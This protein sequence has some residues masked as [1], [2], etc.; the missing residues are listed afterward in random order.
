[1]KLQNMKKWLGSGDDKISTAVQ[2][3][4]T[5]SETDVCKVTSEISNK[6]KRLSRHFQLQKNVRQCDLELC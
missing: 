1:M 3:D 5:H 2:R 6:I 4:V